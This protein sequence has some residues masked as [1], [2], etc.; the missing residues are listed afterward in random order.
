MLVPA[1]ETFFGVKLFRQIPDIPVDDMGASDRS[2]AKRNAE[3][4]SNLARQCLKLRR[5]Q[6]WEDGGSKIIV[7]LRRDPERRYKVVRVEQE[8]GNSWWAQ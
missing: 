6:H 1:I 5:L 2:K 3:I 8:N 7:L 4:A